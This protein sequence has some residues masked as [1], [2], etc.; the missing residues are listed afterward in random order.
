MGIRYAVIKRTLILLPA[1]YKLLKTLHILVKMIISSF[2]TQQE[3][4]L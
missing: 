3:L 2:I 4:Y 1:K